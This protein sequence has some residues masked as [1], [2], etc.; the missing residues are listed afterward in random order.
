MPQAYRLSD[1]PGLVIGLDGTTLP[2]DH[3]DYV[4]WVSDGNTPD[5]AIPP[6]LVY[7]GELP[8]DA[9]IR[10]TDATPT[11]V[12]RRTLAQLTGYAT[13]AA[14]IGVDAGNGAVRVIRASIVAKRLG[15]AA[16]LVGAPVVIA[17]H[18][19]AAA[20]TWAIT[21]TVSGNDFI[22]TVTGAAGR[23]VDWALSGTVRSFTPAGT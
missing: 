13:V 20:S 4:H 19:D 23:T 17:S 2:I 12:Y 10:T 5:P 15:G 7:S 3:A 14:L 16:I 8:M 6:P 11:E 1:R 21:A 22:I 18:A 9:R